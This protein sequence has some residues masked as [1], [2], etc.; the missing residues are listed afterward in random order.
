MGLFRAKIQPDE[1]AVQ[2]LIAV[3]NKVDPDNPI[4]MKDVGEGIA[5]P[6]DGEE[7]VYFS[8]HELPADSPSNVKGASIYC[9]RVLC[10]ASGDRAKDLEMV[11][12][13]NGINCFLRFSVREDEIIIDISWPA[14]IFSTDLFEDTLSQMNSMSKEML[15]GLDQ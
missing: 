12:Q 9:W 15:L 4:T 7:I 10:P 2:S 8:P 13:F 6:I 5:V 11:N 3:L 14:E 1:V